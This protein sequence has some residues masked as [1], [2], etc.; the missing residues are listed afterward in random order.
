MQ[1]FTGVIEVELCFFIFFDVEE[2]GVE[3]L[4]SKSLLS[5]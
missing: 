5:G 4:F 3:K 1:D 2:N